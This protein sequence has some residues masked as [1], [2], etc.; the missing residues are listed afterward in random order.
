MTGDV[1]DQR[2]EAGH[3]ATTLLG[4]KEAL[5][6]YSVIQSHRCSALP[7]QTPRRVRFVSDTHSMTLSLD[8]APPLDREVLSRGGG[9]SRSKYFEVMMATAS[10]PSDSRRYQFR[11]SKIE[12]GRVSVEMAATKPVAFQKS[13]TRTSEVFMASWRH[14]GI[15]SRHPAV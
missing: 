8:F 13:A 15:D 14:L 10:S 4:E 2:T 3:V 11:V 12:G 6:I 5:C 7:L 1:P 9:L